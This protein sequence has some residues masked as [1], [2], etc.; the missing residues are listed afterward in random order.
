[1]EKEKS[2]SENFLNKEVPPETIDINILELEPE[3]EL[4]NDPN[5]KKFVRYLLKNAPSFWQAPGS[6]EEGIHPP[7]EHDI[8]GMIL[9]TKRV[10]RSAIFLA[11]A[12]E[13]ETQ[14]DY[15]CL[16]AAAILHDVAKYIYDEKGEDVV[17]D[18]FHAYAVDRFVGW[19]R[20]ESINL[21]SGSDNAVEIDMQH[22]DLILRL[23]RCSHGVWS[24]IP[25]T[26]PVTELEK[27]LHQADLIAS[28]LHV[29]VDG[30]SV[31]E[32]RWI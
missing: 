19:A 4:I 23:I 5:I 18:P 3:I 14:Y 16:L 11:F 30:D 21:G 32:D 27:T 24:E 10:V 12:I 1:M 26:I 7:D 20:K 9:H 2:I 17:F 8:G 28:N 25:E 6:H 29:I 13:V 15:D 22:L 31:K